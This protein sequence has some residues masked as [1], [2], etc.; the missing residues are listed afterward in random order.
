MKKS[1]IRKKSGLALL[2][3]LLI[4]LILP[5]KLVI[6]VTGATKNDYHPESF[7]YYPWGKSVTHKGVDIFAVRG[8][9]VVS[10]TKG[11][12]LYKG[13]I[14][15]GGNV[16]VVLGPKWRIHYYAHLHEIKTRPLSFVG[17]K[18]IIG[19][20]GST[21]NATGKQPH[22][23]YTIVSLLPHFWRI[24]SSPQGWKKMFFLNPI[25]KFEK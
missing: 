8:K 4:G 25:E 3:L 9:P 14:R 15:M 2:V 16:V 10:A 13:K 11:I 21:G 20:V 1:S 7:W 22:L 12:V 17:Q 19:T 18:T 5:E 24:D 6:P 23:H